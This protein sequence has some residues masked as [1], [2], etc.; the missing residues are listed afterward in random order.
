[1]AMTS[2]SSLHSPRVRRVLDALHAES[3]IVD[4]PL[5]ARAEGTEVGERTA[6]L[7]QA[8]IGVSP[9]AGRF[10]YALVRGCAPGTAVEFGTSFGISTIY[11]AAAVRDR[12]TG[13]VITTERHAVKAAKA[14]QHISEAGLL[15]VV[16]LRV[17]DAL[18]SLKN[19]TQDVSIVFL[20]GWKDLYLPVLHLIEPAMRPGALVVADDLD[21]FPEVLEPYLAYV[22]HPANGYVS[23]DIPIGDAMELSARAG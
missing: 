21:L 17:G 4:P 1:M 3:T 7:D 11:M 10:L 6:L 5:L 19:I 8:F 16:D 23:I 9:E 12:G 15:D 20:D 2:S 13:L 22:R 14:R 18:E